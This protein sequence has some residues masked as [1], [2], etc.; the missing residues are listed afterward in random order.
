MVISNSSSTIKIQSVAAAPA[1]SSTPP[2]ANLAHT[3][4]IIQQLLKYD[5]LMIQF[6]KY[7][8]SYTFD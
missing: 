4:G 8:S 3:S 6:S 7:Q 5:E 1:A 2:V